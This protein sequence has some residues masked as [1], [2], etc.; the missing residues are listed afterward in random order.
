[1]AN[2]PAGPNPSSNQPRAGDDAALTDALENLARQPM[3]TRVVIRQPA[4]KPALLD[5]MSEQESLLRDAARH[6]RE[7]S[8]MEPFSYAAEWLLDNFYVV[9]QTFRQIREDMPPGFYRQLPKISANPLEGIPRIYAVAGEL[10]VNNEAYLEM[11]RV[12]RSVQ[13]FQD[14]TPLTTAELWAL[15]VML[16]LAIMECLTQAVS[17]I[18]GLQRENPLPVLALKGKTTD[19][20]IVANCIISLRTLAIQDWQAFFEKVSRVELVLRTDP[21]QVYPKMDKESRDRYRKVIEELALATGRNEQEVAR[22]AIR[23]AQNPPGDS[24]CETAGEST[25]GTHIPRSLTGSKAPRATHVGTYLL[26]SGRTMLETR[27]GYHPPWHENL[28][29]WIFD[30]ATLVYLGSIWLL[31][32]ILLMGGMSYT[33]NAGAALTQWIGASVLLLVAAVTV[34]VSLVNWII[35]LTV[36]TRILPKMDF[37]D[38]IPPEC[39]TMVVIPSLL[40]SAIEVDSLLRQL[41]L[42]FLRN[43]DSHL[44]FALL[45]DL[46]DAPQPRRPGSEALV[47][48]AKSGIQALNE[49]Y[50]RQTANPFFI[51]HRDAM[52]NPREERWMGWERKRGKLHQLNLILRGGAEAGFRMQMG[53]LEV[54]PGIKYVIT[55]DADTIL[56]PQA[57]CR[58]VATIAHPLNR[59]EFDSRNGA[60][61]AGYTLLQPRME[62]AS[63]SAIRSPFTRIFTRDVGLDPYTQAVSNVYQ[64]LFGEGIY[65]GK[66]IYDVDAFERSLSGRI[67]ENALLSHDLIEGVHGRVGLVT[68]IVL[69][70]DFPP[71]YLVYVRRSRRWI[72]GDWQLLP[73][74]L[75]RVPSAGKGTIPNDLSVIDRWKI[76]DN[77][78]RSLLSPALLGLFVAGWLLLPGSPLAWTLFG[79]LTPAVPVFTGSVL[80]LLRTVKGRSWQG[81]LQPLRKGVIRWIL[82]LVLLPYEI[83]L[84]LGGII[85]TLARLFVSRKHLLQWTTAADTVRLFAGAVTWKKMFSA[86]LLTAVLALL[87]VL[88]NPSALPVAAP[89]LIAWFI[90]PQVVHWVSRPTRYAPTSLSTDQRQLLRHLARRTWLFFEHGVGPEDHWL[91]PDHLQETPRGMIAHSTSPTN[92]GMLL[93]STLAAYDLGYIGLLD[94]SSRLLNAFE[95]ME[96]LERYR[97]HFLNWYDTRRLEPLPPRYVSTVDSGNLAACLRT[98]GQGCRALVHA[99]VLRWQTWEGC[100]DTLSL[101]GDVMKDLEAAGLRSAVMPCQARLARIQQQIQAVK[102][103]RLAWAPLPLKLAGEFENELVPLLTSLVESQ[104]KTIDAEALRRLSFSIDR[105]RNHLYGMKREI[106]RLLPWLSFLSQPPRLLARSNVP[107]AVRD[108][109]QSLRDALPT[110][111]NLEEL[112]EVCKAGQATLAE[113]QSELDS[114]APSSDLTAPNQGWHPGGEFLPD[115]ARPEH[116][117]WVQEARDWC[118]RLAEKLESA[119]TAAQSLLIDFKDLNGQAERYFQAIDFGFLFN[120]Q[121]LVFHIGYNVETEKLDNNCYDLLASEARIAS[122]VAIAKNEVPL[123]H[124]LHLGRPLT[125]VEGTRALLSWDASMFEYLMPAQLMRNYEGTL[126]Q[127][128]CRAAIDHQIIYGKQNGV[129]WGI[130]ESG[131]YAFDANLN[132]QYRGFGVP[133]LGFRRNL[134][135]DLVVAPY[136]SLLALPFRPRKVMENIARLTKLKM[137]GVY[138]FYESV[139]F[140]PSRLPPGAKHAIVHS[141][142]AHHQGLILLSLVNG[143]QDDVMVRRFHSDPLMQSIEL[144]LQEKTPYDVPL[145]PLSPEEARVAERGPVQPQVV[146][147]PWSVPVQAAA[148]Q[149]HFLSNGR[150]GLLI[151]SAGGGFS[152]WRETDLT[153]WRA[154]TTLDAWG[155]WIY[156]QDKES[157]AVWSAA[158]QPMGAPPESQTVQFYAHLAEFRRSDHGIHLM[159]EITVRPDEDVEIRRISLTNHSDRF[160]RLALTSYGEIVLAPQAVDQRHP[161]F[162]KMFIESEHLPEINALLFRRRPRS[163]AEEPIYLAHFAVAQPRYKTKHAY[164]NNRVRFLGRGRSFRDPAALSP[165]QVSELAG[166]LPFTSAPLDPIMAIVQEIELQPHATVQVAFVTLAAESRQKALS[167]SGRYRAWREIE[168]AFDLSRSHSEFELSQLGL[169]AKDL[170]GIQQLLSL[171]LYPHAALRAAPET[172]AA[173]RKGPPGLWAFGLSGDYPILLVHLNSQDELGLVQKALQAHAFWRNRQIKIDLVILNQQGSSYNQEMNGQL[174]RLLARMNSRDW[175]NRRGGVFVLYA[176]QMGGADRVLLE[177]A[178]RVVL[179]GGKGSLGDQLAALRKQ[180]T[181]LPPFNPVP[182]D[183]KEVESTPRLARPTDLLFDNG[184]GGFSADGREY[185]IYLEP[186]QRTPAPWVNVIANP[187]FGFL[188]SEAGGGYTWSVNSGENRLTPWSNDPVT[189]PPGEAFYLRD[190][191]T[192]QVWSPTPSP[193]PAPAPYLIRHGAGYSVFEHNSHGLRQRLRLFAVRDAPVKVMQLRLE[194]TW[195]YTRRITATF[196]LEWVLGATRDITQQYIVSKFDSDTQTLLARNAYNAEFAERV[197]F[198]TANKRLHGLTADRTEFLGRLGNHGH[199]AALDRIGLAGVVEPGLD[200]CAALMLHLDLKPGEAEEIFFLVGEGA[201]QE[202]ALRLVRQYQDAK[203]V[204]AAWQA[205][206]GF[207]DDLLASVQVRT[208]DPAMNLLLNRWLLYQTLSC[209]VW[210]RSAFYQSS[211]AFGFRDQLQDVMALLH[212]APHLAREHILRSAG[213]QFEAGDVLHWWHPPSGSGVRTRCSDDLLWLPFITAQYVAATG[214][215]SILEEKEPFRKAVPLETEEEN[216]YGRYP[217]SDEADTLYEHCRR[218]LEKGTTS[219]PH[220]LPLIGSGD[221]NDALNRVGIKG[222]GESVWLG[223]FLHATLTRMAGLCD[224]KGDHKPGATYRRRASDLSQALEANAWDGNWYLRAYFDDGML[225]GSATNRECQIDSIAQSWAVLSEAGDPARAAQAIESVINHLLRPDDQLLLLFNPPFDKTPHDPGYIKGYPPGI[226]ENGGQY[227]HAALWVAWAFARLGQGDRAE[228]LF[229]LLNPIYQ[230]DTPKKAARYKVEPYVVAADVYS[231]PPHTGRGGWTWYTGSSAW[232]YRLGLE[233]ILGIRRMDK[234][235]HIDPCIPKDWPHYQVSYRDKKTTWQIRVDNPRGVNRGVKQVTLDGQPL[236]GNEIPLLDDSGQHQVHIVMG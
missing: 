100:L 131:Y 180:P 26:D 151:T 232:M 170:D 63:V 92:L 157:G 223:W 70:E 165:R 215:E 187:D 33:R 54:L 206:T 91:P 68:D 102:N 22:E 48:R 39:R 207:W 10:V 94:L 156:L 5:Y 202:E 146:P 14:I 9:Q 163:E 111:P 175:L 51:F 79:L 133:G 55:L 140:T 58:L 184:L 57:A 150:Y 49:R 65:V 73:W 34:S 97:G 104:T 218:A 82:S 27:L 88:F 135:E 199:P 216:R 181:H 225:L 235:L 229:R 137:L 119:A 196:Y 160:R 89:L 208:P 161:A 211:G 128:S 166:S 139:D 182:P 74:L 85:V 32:L 62:I 143:L 145:E 191:Q 87:T 109:W 186:G 71:H 162:N 226:R 47:E 189:D 76:L 38:G 6:F 107:P 197:A 101:L 209:R 188:V 120:P 183:S 17:R 153:R 105:A 127:H 16:R 93:L 213:H 148:P 77:L 50:L 173:N 121:R 78:R 228:F 155:T 176:D 114:L 43:Q 75:P 217:T 123:S 64:D 220:G 113:L 185:V 132:Y 66:C 136:A 15:P 219:G 158:C 234:T 112:G 168:R 227:T 35:T 179:N 177:T 222:R 1:M 125:Q 24:G 122:L 19:D 25:N 7:L 60:V 3:Q 142:M 167:L 152:R 21:A 31:A 129:P 124:W 221:W 30:H 115:E 169:A 205:V 214:D 20:E 193:C 194:N 192:A 29:R 233:A 12:D 56:P 40:T 147:A 23:L 61:V 53:D 201:D 110:T 195:K 117:E 203:Q 41:E 81:A 46:P 138:G 90:S 84:T 99:P 42:H 106:E 96:K 149:V 83:I 103:N 210:G 174:Q 134:A 172:L 80:G 4:H 204:K 13:L 45:T 236:P 212:A 11:D 95:S 159:M 2:K 44:Y 178:A 108:A 164:E 69:F 200:P 72:R 52:W 67:P 154:D 144:L 116:A 141:Y 230:S 118:L 98:L 36:P 231:V 130:S 59:A 198:V 18:M 171:L 8:G 28:R 224:L 86:L 126:L 37:S 190:E